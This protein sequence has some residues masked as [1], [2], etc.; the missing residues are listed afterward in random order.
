MTE[1]R[2]EAIRARLADI[3]RRL[4]EPKFG[5]PKYAMDRRA[6]E[7]ELRSFTAQVLAALAA[8]TEERDALE[9]E[10]NGWADTAAEYLSERDAARADA[11]R[12]ARYA[13]HTRSCLNWTWPESCDCGFDTQVVPIVRGLS[14]HRSLR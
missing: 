4:D 2:L 5:N 13:Q 8:V 7:G 11:E 12:L 3:E 14:A 9:T 10:R 1:D 6:L